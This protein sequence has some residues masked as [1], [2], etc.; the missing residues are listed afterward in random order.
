MA[1]LYISSTFSD[2]QD[3]RKAVYD[4]LR[5]A[6]HD[7]VA[8]EDYVATDQRPLD[9]CLADVAACDVYVGIF[10]WRYGYIP[11]QGNP[12]RKSITELEYR[13]AGELGKACL[14]FLL[15]ENVPW[16]RS[17]QDVVS[18]AGD[19]GQRIDTLRQELGAGLLAGFFKSPDQL[20]G[21]VSAAIANWEEQQRAPTPSDSSIRSITVTP[22]PR[23]ISRHLYLV[24]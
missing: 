24:Y 15:D 14:V 20:A 9:K 16:P 8:M 4:I 5:K 7:V 1:H 23:E 18:G 6:R 12:E 22:Q 3:Y 11:D 13:K 19:R 10:A 17:A 2:L 21:L